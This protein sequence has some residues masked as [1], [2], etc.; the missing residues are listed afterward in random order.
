M[1]EVRVCEDDEVDVGGVDASGAPPVEGAANRM[2]VA[3]LA[4]L[5]NI[6][7]SQIEIVAGLTSER[8]L[9]SLS[10]ERQALEKRYGAAA[11]GIVSGKK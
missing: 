5:L 6:D 4:E 3:F 2:L 7:E 1:V 9:I 8:K 10:I 11:A